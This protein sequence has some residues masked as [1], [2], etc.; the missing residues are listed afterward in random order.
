MKTLRKAYPVILTPTETGYS[1]YI[2]D[3]NINTQG[4]DLADALYMARDAIGIMGIDME[5]D[6]MEIPNPKS[7]KYDCTGD[8]MVSLVDI[9]FAEYRRLVDNR[10]VKKNCTIPSWMNERAE[11]AHVIFSKVLQDALISIVGDYSY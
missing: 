11:K 8:E 1:V 6:G 9:D 2:P 7:V 5:D 3:F 4:E 10:V